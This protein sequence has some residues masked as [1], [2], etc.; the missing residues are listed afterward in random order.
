MYSG[1]MPYGER[2]QVK[3]DLTAFCPGNDLVAATALAAADVIWYFL[4]DVVL[5]S[6]LLFQL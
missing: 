3:R 4:P 6:V 1:V 5:L 2:L